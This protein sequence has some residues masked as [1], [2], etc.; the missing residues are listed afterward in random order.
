MKKLSLILFSLSTFLIFSYPSVSSEK[1]ISGKAKV[2]DV[3]TI[4]INKKKLDF[5]VSTHQKN[6]GEI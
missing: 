1:T 4:K 6:G 2:I 5:L 3:D